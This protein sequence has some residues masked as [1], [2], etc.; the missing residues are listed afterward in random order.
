M[1]NIL[2]L[3]DDEEM[4]EELSDILK[5]EKHLFDVANLLR[6]IKELE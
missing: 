5:R 6:K 3:D 2:I 1:A 4:C